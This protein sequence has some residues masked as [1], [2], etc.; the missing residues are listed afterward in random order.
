MGTCET[1]LIARVVGI[2]I[3]LLL[4]VCGAGGATSSSDPLPLHRECPPGNER[5]PYPTV[6][7]DA[8][9]AQA[10]RALY[11]QRVTIQG[12]T[13]VLGPRNTDLAAAMR[14][15]NLSL[16]PGMQR[17]YKVMQHRCG[18]HA[19]AIAWAFEFDV[20]TNAPDFSPAYVV[21]TARAWYVF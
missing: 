5:T 2:A 14:V 4:A 13:L 19:P 7:F 10:K 12:Q 20:P 8:A 15:E 17:W 3:V 1:S 11:G 6:R 9:F 18:A 21:R 16:V